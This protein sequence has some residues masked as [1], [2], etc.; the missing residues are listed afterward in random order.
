M[1]D[2]ITIIIAFF[3]L[4][5]SVVSLFVSIQVIQL[6]I[7]ITLKNELAESFRRYLAV[8]SVNNDNEG[9]TNECGNS[10]F[11]EFEESEFLNSLEAIC[12]FCNK[13]TILCSA[14]GFLEPQVK[15]IVTICL[16]DEDWRKRLK[17]QQGSN[18]KYK[19]IRCFAKNIA[20]NRGYNEKRRR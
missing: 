3:S 1:H 7:V 2:F 16:R 20:S 13:K 9:A 12:F 17:P 10:G 19:E 18:E 5:F 14:K 6:N 11:E 15:E 4:V 8:V